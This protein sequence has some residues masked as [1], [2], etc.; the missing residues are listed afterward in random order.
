MEPMFNHTQFLH[1]FFLSDPV[2]SL[3]SRKATVPAI[4][5]KYFP[6]HSGDYFTRSEMGP[7]KLYE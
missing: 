6:I 3:L 1:F 7:T 5:L 4:E 2:N